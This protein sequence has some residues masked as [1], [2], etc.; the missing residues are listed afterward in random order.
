MGIKEFR[1]YHLLQ[2]SF[3]KMLG[4]RMSEVGDLKAELSAYFITSGYLTKADI[5]ALNVKLGAVAK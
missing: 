5:D 4:K 1:D 2:Y 3:E